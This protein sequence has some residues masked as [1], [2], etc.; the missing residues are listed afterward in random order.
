[1]HINTTSDLKKHFILNR[2]L[3]SYRNVI[4]QAMQYCSA[5]LAETKDCAGCH[6]V[7]FYKDINCNVFLQPSVSISNTCM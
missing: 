5:S 6:L 3:N 1:M 2:N 7:N 4:L